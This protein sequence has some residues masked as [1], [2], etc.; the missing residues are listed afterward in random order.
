MLRCGSALA[1]GHEQVGGRPAA[2]DGAADA[3]SPLAFARKIIEVW[4]ATAPIPR[5]E[6]TS[7]A[8]LQPPRVA[9]PSQIHREPVRPCPQRP[10]GVLGSLLAANAFA[11]SKTFER[12][13]FAVRTP[14]KI[15]RYTG[16][17]GYAEISLF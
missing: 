8:W 10:T 3:R 12:F 2:V 9:Q 11:A 17:A 1:Y 5:T 4:A 7:L 14:S 6:L 16:I 13:R 15:A